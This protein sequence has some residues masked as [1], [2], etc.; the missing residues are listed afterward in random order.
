[1]P[2]GPAARVGDS[3]AHGAPLAPGPGSTT[4]MIG[5]MPA[6]RGVSAAGAASV[7][8]AV[9]SAMAAIAAAQAAATAASGTP[10]FP[11]AQAN[12]VKTAVEQVAAVANTMSSSGGD[13]L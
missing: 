3:S 1:M 2:K 4:V 6:W 13:M 8:A 5:G 12:L 11:A 10:G 9:S 7:T